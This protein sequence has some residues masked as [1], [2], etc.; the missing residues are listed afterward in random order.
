[1]S[2]DSASRL[3][4]TY[5]LS[6]KDRQLAALKNALPGASAEFSGRKRAGSSHCGHCGLAAA[7]SS[8]KVPFIVRLW[9]EAICRALSRR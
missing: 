6:V 1:M 4:Q 8:G 2:R 5:A 3:M 7:A 9:A